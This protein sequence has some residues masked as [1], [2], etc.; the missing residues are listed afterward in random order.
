MN[1]CCFVKSVQLYVTNHLKLIG[2]LQLISHSDIDFKA[3]QKSAD[4]F[5]IHA[6]MVMHICMSRPGHWFMQ[7]YDTKQVSSHYL[8]Q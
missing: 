1:L 2:K 3:I 5:V 7:G 6:G 8:S 4:A